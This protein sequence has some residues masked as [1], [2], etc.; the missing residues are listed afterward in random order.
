MNKQTNK[1]KQSKQTNGFALSNALVYGA[2]LPFLCYVLCLI[3][4]KVSW[5]LALLGALK[6][7]K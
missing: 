3:S 7:F 1:T 5:F 6:S 2:T 4:P